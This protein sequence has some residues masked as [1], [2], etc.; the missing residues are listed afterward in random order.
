M[1]WKK[2][3]TE[4]FRKNNQVSK[5]MDKIWNEQGMFGGKKHEFSFKHM[6]LEFASVTSN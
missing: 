6:E 1:V 3:N 5:W 4:E 2:R